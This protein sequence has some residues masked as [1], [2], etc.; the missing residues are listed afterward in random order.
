MSSAICSSLPTVLFGSWIIISPGLDRPSSVYSKWDL[1]KTSPDI[2]ETAGSI[3]IRFQDFSFQVIDIVIQK[4]QFHHSGP[5]YVAMGTILSS[6]YFKQFL[7]CLL[8]TFNFEKSSIENA[9]MLGGLVYCKQSIQSSLVGFTV[10]TFQRKP[11][12]SNCYCYYPNWLV[13]S[14]SFFP[15]GVISIIAPE[16]LWVTLLAFTYIYF[17]LPSVV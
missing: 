12:P 4:N 3:E 2:F 11:L 7:H 16:I 9:S 5:L 6:I 17:K 15:R 10:E 13:S 8:D 1:Y 14:S